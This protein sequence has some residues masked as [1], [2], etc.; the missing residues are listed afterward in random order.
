MLTA[1]ILICSATATCTGDENAATVIRVPVECAT[2]ATC[3]M[4]AQAFLAQTSLGRDL[5]PS[6]TVK[7]ICVRS[8]AAPTP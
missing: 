3:F 8:G 1:L 4:N 2:P 6:D 5:G 7:I